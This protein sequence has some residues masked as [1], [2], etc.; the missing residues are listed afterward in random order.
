METE[1]PVWLKMP[2]KREIVNHV[3]PG[4]RDDCLALPA[5]FKNTPIHQRGS[6]GSHLCQV[7]WGL[8]TKRQ[9][10]H[11]PLYLQHF[12]QPNN[13]QGSFY[14][15]LHSQL[16]RYKKKKKGRKRREGRTHTGMWAKVA[17]ALIPCRDS[18]PGQGARGEWIFT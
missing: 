8:L 14:L 13:I 9:A 2:L 6:R 17:P 1:V 11:T 15:F 4:G 12:F 7:L 3:P 18:P 10:S 16:Q 5:E